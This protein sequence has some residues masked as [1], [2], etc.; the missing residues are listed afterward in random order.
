MK[1][2]CFLICFCITFLFS[3]SNEN[4]VNY[5]FPKTRWNMEQ[6]ELLQLYDI[7]DEDIILSND[8]TLIVEGLNVFGEKTSQVCFQFI[9]P[10]GKNTLTQIEVSYPDNTDMQKVLK[11]MKKIYGDV[12]PALSFFSY[13]NIVETE[14]LEY[15]CEET[16]HLKLWSSMSIKDNIPTDKLDGYRNVWSKYLKPI[17]IDDNWNYFISNAYMIGIA[18][19]DN[20]EIPMLRDKYTDSK[21]K[22]Y[23][24]GNNH[25]F[26][27]YITKELIK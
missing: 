4:N 25:K 18:W 7:K 19:T 8:Y 23:F 13:Y 14:F 17:S 21:N 9:D 27:E 5:E 11:S 20:N 26:Y 6:I 12:T 10:D 22:V 24:E 16:E 15:S 1:K 3:C 2:L